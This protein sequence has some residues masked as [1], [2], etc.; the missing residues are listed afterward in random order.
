[1]RVSDERSIGSVLK[2]AR[3][4]L[5]ALLSLLLFAAAAW[6]LRRELAG[7]HLSDVLARFRAVPI[8]A[9]GLSLLFTAASYLT[10]TG[11]DLL[12]LRYAGITLPYGRIALTSFIATAVGN[13]LGLA[14]LSGGAVRLRMYSAAGLTAME[15]AAVVAMVGLTFGIGVTVIAALVLALDP[16]NA[17]RLLDIPVGLT[18]GAGLL[19]IALVGIYLV[20]GAA[21]RTP[22][23]LGGWKIR[24]PGLPT[25]VG[26][27]ALAAADLVF[28]SGALY[29]LLPDGL[30]PAYAVFLT[31]YI[32]AIVAGTIS[33][34][35]GGIG[36]FE[37]VLVLGLPG[38]PKDAL[39]AAV[40]IYRLI[41]YLLPLALAALLAAV[42]EA[43]LAHRHIA[44]GLELAQDALEGV[45]PQVMAVA[46]F[47][48]GAILMFSGST[49]GSSNR[50]ELL[51]DLLPLPLLELSH[52][53]GSLVGLGLT[54]LAAGLYRRLNAAYHLALG[55]LIIG[56]L[57]SVLKGLDW[58]EALLAGLAAA[59]LWTGRAAFYRQ[60]SLWEQRL[61]PGWLAAV[62]LALGG[63]IWL[64][65]FAFKRIEY[66]HDLWWQFAFDADAPRFLRATL[67][68]V[69]AATLIAL[70]RLL[71]P[72]PPPPG[73][74][75]SEELRRAAALVREASATDAALVLLGDKRILFDEQDDGFLMFQIRGRSWIVMGDPVGPPQVAE[76]LAWR[77]RDL[78]DRYSGRPVFYQVD[79]EHLPLY[80][81]LGLAPIKIGEEAVVDLVS[82]SL[83]GRTRA[84]LR[85]SHSK[86]VK[87]G[88]R[89]NV[90]AA[91]DLDDALMGELKGVSD[92]WLEAKKTREKGFSVGRFDPDYLRHFPCGL[93]RRDGELLAFANLW[94]GGGKSELSVD[95]MRHLPQAPNGVM[96][97]LFVELMLWG[98][99]EG[100]R[101][102]NLGMA[103]LS[104]LETHP[105]A[106]LWH[107]IGTL[108]FR[109]G[110]NFYNF[111]GLRAY[112]E[113]FQPQWAPKYLA[114]PRGT[115]LPVVLLDLS[116]LIAGGARGI[117]A[118]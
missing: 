104:G 61:T 46:V 93:A 30:A 52:L 28:A 59:A 4:V 74:P 5:Y 94:A 89:F 17:G 2:G 29:S 86:I 33:H 71:R 16:G 38:V 8:Q 13:N 116:T 97:F 25:S 114:L 36:V 95:L 40:L 24:V 6:V 43:Q 48:A 45:V 53:T 110:E 15:V 76:T 34:I 3:P 98:A 47:V 55:L 57:T 22:L 19:V 56:A 26:Q 39:L 10:L 20:W 96:D 65:L 66:D 108:T 32:L 101:R 63:S 109:H 11:Y 79:A 58:E 83:T 69:T 103:P 75:E 107:R 12:A 84:K 21:R 50:I 42:H 102:F 54:V 68:L 31:V 118:R 23:R 27:I 70:V 62:A 87:T 117:V 111:Q 77:F 90:V 41:Y 44:R 105:L 85:Q 35:P 67:L 64:G 91:E 99:S 1:M 92:A 115:A 88:I 14:M 73:L 112:K 18:R 80:L 100:F 82:F 106:P 78:A 37:T 60:S 72:A 81:D 7:V 113:K 51:S 49:P 9:L